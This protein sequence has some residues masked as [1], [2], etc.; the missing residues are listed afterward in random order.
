MIVL[1]FDVDGT[2]INTRGAGRD[3]MDAA[4]SAEF[5]I[6]Q[7]SDDLSTLGR[8]DRGIG[9][10][11]FRR[12]GI[13]DNV[14]NWRRLVAAYL[15]RL[16]D[17]LHRLRG[18]LL[19]GVGELLDVLA[20]RRDVAVGLLTGNVQQAA[21]IKLDHFGIHGHFAF[22]GYGDDHP[23]RDDV[24]RTAQR[25]AADHL[26]GPRRL[27]R[28]IVIGDTT[29]DVRCA[30]TIGAT[31]VAVA[32]GLCPAAELQAA[33]PDLLL[34]NLADARPLLALCGE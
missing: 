29:L 27:R 26:G 12:H 3:A 15:R 16:P 28:V 17:S 11:M 30:R 20:A 6:H 31:A 32:S 2:L 22:G 14:D 19:P 7:S 13:E 23:D 8:T 25:A 18:L 1:L 9:A 4:L 21:R 24:A 10:A 5:G 33:R 34:E